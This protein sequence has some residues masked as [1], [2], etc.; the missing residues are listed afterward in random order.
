MWLGF[1]VTREMLD[2]QF[3][4]L[5]S[6]VTSIA[7]IFS[8]CIRLIHFLVK[9]HRFVFGFTL[10]IKLKT[11]EVCW[12]VFPSVSN[13]IFPVIVDEMAGNTFDLGPFDGIK[14]IKQLGTRL[15][16][17]FTGATLPVL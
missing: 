7:H 8:D 17:H 1:H 10:W 9:D 11:K 3:L 2:Q 12:M 14:V 4:L 6:S 16:D 5:E 13:K 15:K